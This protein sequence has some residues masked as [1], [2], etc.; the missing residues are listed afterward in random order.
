LRHQRH[1]AYPWLQVRGGCVQAH[2]RHD[3]AE[4]AGTH[5]PDARCPGRCHQARH[6][7]QARRREGAARC[8]REQHSRN[9]AGLR[10]NY[11]EVRG[12]GERRHV[13]IGQDPAYGGD[14]I[15]N[16][17][18][19]SLVAASQQVAHHGRAHACAGADHS[20]GV[21]TEQAGRAKASCDAGTE[22]GHAIQLDCA[23]QH[24]PEL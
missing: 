4:G 8:K 20:D 6:R 23:V 5:H 22:K 13:G 21:R 16:R 12:N 15:L 10:R 2:G 9:G 11:R 14:A 3:Q 24:N 1:L 19:C 7:R 17:Q 18:D